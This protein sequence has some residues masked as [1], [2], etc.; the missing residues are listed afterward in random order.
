MVVDHVQDCGQDL[1][2]E[3]D[4]GRGVSAVHLVAHPQGARDQRLERDTAHAAK[5]LPDDR[6][7]HVVDVL[8]S[9]VHALVVAAVVE[10][11]GFLALVEVAE[12][13]VAVRAVLDD[14]HR[15]GRG[16]DPGQ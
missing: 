15:H 1:A 2:I 5:G 7:Q 14:E 12:P 16:V 11:A 3:Q 10:P 8:Q 6:G 4:R 9:V 13:E